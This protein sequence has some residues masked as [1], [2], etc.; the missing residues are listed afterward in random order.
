MTVKE[1]ALLRDN[2]DGFW[3]ERVD[4]QTFAIYHKGFHT[5]SGSISDAKTLLRDAY[6][7]A[8]QRIE[9]EAIAAGF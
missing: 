8:M 9:R 1:F 3:V 5:R 7:E 6:S 2:W 4:Y